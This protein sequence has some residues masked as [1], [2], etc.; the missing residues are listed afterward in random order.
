MKDDILKYPVLRDNDQK[1]PV[2]LIGLRNNASSTI[3]QSS[4]NSSS[5]YLHKIEICLEYANEII[6][7]LG[8][9][10]QL[11]PLLSSE[12]AITLINCA[13]LYSEMASELLQRAYTSN[14]TKNKLWTIAGEQVK[15]GLGLLH[16]LETFLIEHNINT[17]YTQQLNKHIDEYQILY[18]L[19][20]I[21]LSFLKLKIIMS[22]PENNKLDLQT[23]DLGSTAALCVFNSKLSMGCYNSALG[24]TKSNLVTKE[25]L[26]F[27]LGSI[28]LLMSIDN[29]NIDEVGIAIGMLDEVIN[30]FS[31]IIPRGIITKTSLEKESSSKFSKSGL[32][33]RKDLLKNKLHHVSNKSSKIIATNGSHAL[34]PVLIDV[35]NDF[36]IP[37][38]VLLRY[39]YQ[40]TN[41]KV[42][43]K[44]VEKD[45][46]I[47][48]SKFPIGKSPK[49]K[50]ERW[51]IINGQLEPESPGGTNSNGN[52]F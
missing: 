31:I 51:M 33:K 10:T 50:G 22:N 29:F 15:K 5:S 19:S 20:I 4:D 6:N 25:L 28:F 35:L 24:L 44:P 39:V 41:D 21:V 32:L 42:T 2:S 26:A 11:L 45:I 7:S 23:N 8:G 13:I 49:M 37:L 14:D 17:N 3:A 18:Q 48:K 9:E 1:L 52:Y 36:L 40:R 34:L 43:F 27:L 46:E 16:F 38:I 47:L 12:L 30:E